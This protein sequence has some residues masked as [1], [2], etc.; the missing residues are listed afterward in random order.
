VIYRA[1]RETPSEP[2]WSKRG[3]QKD[4][5]ASLRPVFLKSN[6]KGA[7]VKTDAPYFHLVLI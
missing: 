7:T 2:Y 6:K 4:S 3:K 5:L 1:K